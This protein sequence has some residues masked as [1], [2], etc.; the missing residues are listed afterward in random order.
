MSIDLT[1]MA[2]LGFEKY[3]LNFKN[4]NDQIR[5]F[6]PAEINGIDPEAFHILPMPQVQSHE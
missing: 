6:W 1:R 4:G 2:K 5:E 3:T